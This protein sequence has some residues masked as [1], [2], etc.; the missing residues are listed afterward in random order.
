M[1]Q[2]F[3]FDPDHWHCSQCII[4][5]G[6]GN[7]MYWVPCQAQDIYKKVLRPC[8][9]RCKYGYKNIEIAIHGCQ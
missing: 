8:I 1:V 5:T 7:W 3:H 2:K 6:K 9:C 4:S